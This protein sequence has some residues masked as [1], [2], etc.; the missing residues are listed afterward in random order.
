MRSAATLVGPKT[1]PPHDLL[2]TPATPF[3]MLT[4]HHSI[5]RKVTISNTDPPQPINPILTENAVTA[6]KD[7]NGT[8]RFAPFVRPRSDTREHGP[9][10][11]LPGTVH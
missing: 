8:T 3:G 2:S 7:P 10:P 6:S 5:T 4:Q 9:F 11:H 1:Y